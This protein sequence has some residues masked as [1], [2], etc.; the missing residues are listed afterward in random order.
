MRPSNRARSLPATLTR[1]VQ[2][3]LLVQEG[4]GVRATAAATRWWPP[5]AVS[6]RTCRRSAST[7]GTLPGASTSARAASRPARSSRP[8]DARCAA[9]RPAAVTRPPSGVQPPVPDESLVRFRRVVAAALAELESRRQEV[10][11]L[12]VFPVA[13]GDTGDNMAITLRAVVE[14]LNAMNGEPIDEIGRD[15]IVARGGPRGPAR[16]ARQQRRDPL[17]DRARRGRGARLAAG[18]A[19][20]PDPGLRRLR[21]RRRRRLRLGARPR[22]GHDALRRARDGQPRGARPRAHGHA[23]PRARRHRR[24]AGRAAGRGARER[25][26][27]GQGGR[28]A[29]PRAAGRSCA[30]PAWS[31]PAPTGSP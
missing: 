29:R 14:E 22:R 24:G 31:T 15:E 17:A 13:D 16:R 12:N 26:R 2:G 19:R 9:F 11:D 4:P 3:L 23:A 20:R 18:R 10:N 27:G 21:A 1:R 7:S 25:A 8:S 28:R 30:R 6:T 5:G